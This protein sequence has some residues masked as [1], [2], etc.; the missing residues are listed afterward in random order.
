MASLFNS[1]IGFIARRYFYAAAF[2]SAATRCTV[3]SE[4]S[5]AFAAWR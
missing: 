3:P 5:P 2:N 4:T 1:P